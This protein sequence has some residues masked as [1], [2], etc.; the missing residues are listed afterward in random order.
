VSRITQWLWFIPLER[1]PLAMM[2]EDRAVFLL[3]GWS[4]PFADS[5]SLPGMPGCSKMLMED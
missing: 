1:V 4:V 5:L 2:R 3:R